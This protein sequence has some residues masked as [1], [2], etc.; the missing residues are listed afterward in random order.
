M[1]RGENEFIGEGRSGKVGGEKEGSR[2]CQRITA[3]VQGLQTEPDHL[4][5]DVSSGTSVL[6]LLTG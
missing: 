2:M 1:V 4:W 5:E 6:S 3:F